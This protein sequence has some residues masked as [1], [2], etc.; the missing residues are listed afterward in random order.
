MAE[1]R[2]TKTF[3]LAPMKT[4]AQRRE[5][6]VHYNFIIRN[7]P[8][9]GS[10]VST[11]GHGLLSCPRCGTAWR[12]KREFCV[13]C[14]HSSGLDAEMYDGQPLNEVLDLIDTSDAD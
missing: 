12:V 10:P 8:I 1:N 14:L 5:N 9:N 6:A 11:A 7:L 4:V 13:S 3:R 2:W